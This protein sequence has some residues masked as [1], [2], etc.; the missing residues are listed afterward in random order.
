MRCIFKDDV[1]IHAVRIASGRNALM[2][3]GKDIANDE[4]ELSSEFQVEHEDGEFFLYTRAL[5]TR[6]LYDSSIEKRK[7]AT[8]VDFKPHGRGHVYFSA[9]FTDLVLLLTWDMGVINGEAFLYDII[10]NRIL[11]KI[12]FEKDFITHVEIILPDQYQYAEL[13]LKDG[14]IWKGDVLDGEATGS[15]VLVNDQG[16]IVFEGMMLKNMREGVGVE[17]FIDESPHRRSYSGMWSNDLRNGIGTSFEKESG[18]QCTDIWMD[19]NVGE[20]K[21]IVTEI[22]PPTLTPGIQVLCIGKNSCPSGEMFVFTHFPNLTHLYINNGAC[23]HGWVLEFCHLH[24]LV[25]VKI[26]D[27]TFTEAPKQ[28]GDSRSFLCRVVDCEQLKELCIGQNSLPFF[29]LE[30]QSLPSLET[31]TMGTHVSVTSELEANGVA[32]EIVETKLEGNVNSFALAPSFVL[33]HAKNLHFLLIGD[34]SFV[35]TTEF[36][37]EA[38]HLQSLSFGNEAFQC[39]SSPIFAVPMPELTTVR[40]ADR[41]FQ[42]SV[43]FPLSPAISSLQLG[44]YAFTV[45]KEVPFS[46]MPDS[47]PL[48]VDF[49]SLQLLHIG[50]SSL[51]SISHFTLRNLS[52]LSEVIV[53][54]GGCTNVQDVDMI[55]LPLLKKMTFCS[56]SFIQGSRCHIADVPVLESI[57]IG[58]NCFEMGDNFVLVKAPSLKWLSLLSNCF[59]HC[60]EFSLAHFTE[61]ETIHLGKNA[62]AN[63]EV[64]LTDALASLKKLVLEEGSCRG[65]EGKEHMQVVKLKGENSGGK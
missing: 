48:F 45:V 31:F 55:N 29:K 50:S 9:P 65:M 46:G 36:F 3:S 60:E 58:G 63:A 56:G 21:A 47:S 54:A 41:S 62:F 17:F 4:E 43:V 19:G 61:L 16:V 1:L 13:A 52:S 64:F 18:A 25:S 6:L 14:C 10:S 51:V 37:L 33:S 57:E 49:S 24:H 44:R 40:I 42:E 26:G 39:I 32:E 12:Q 11:E 34:G 53:D 20:K 30:T 15:G 7:E 23:T 8:F 38:P 28:T 59:T 22:E 2:L 35:H 27:G 5:I